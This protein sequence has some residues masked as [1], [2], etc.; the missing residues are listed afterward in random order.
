MTKHIYAN[1]APNAWTDLTTDKDCIVSNDCLSPVDWYKSNGVMDS[2][3]MNQTPGYLT[4][5]PF[6]NVHFN[7]KDYRVSPF[8]FQ[9]I[10]D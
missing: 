9:I 6:V 10:T 8:D 1:L 3:T 2:L 4:D 5:Y 7:G